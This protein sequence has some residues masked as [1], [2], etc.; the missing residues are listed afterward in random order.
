NTAWLSRKHELQ[1]KLFLPI[2]AIEAS[3]VEADVC[4]SVFHHPYN[5]LDANNYRLLK[6]AVEQTSDIVFTGHEHVP[7][8]G[9]VIRFSGEHLRY[10]EAP[11][12]NGE[13]DMDS[14]FSVLV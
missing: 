4:V 11:A 3:P 6:D 1:S 14:G 12:L 5:W 10:V 7:G 2:D 9:E 8:G 13:S